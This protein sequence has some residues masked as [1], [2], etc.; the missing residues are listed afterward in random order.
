M[1]KELNDHAWENLHVRRETLTQQVAR[2]I[3]EI[4]MDGGFAPGDRIPT[5]RELCD[6]LNVSRTVVR[7][8]IKALQER[9]L[10][11][12]IPGSGTYISRIEG[13]QISRSISLFVRGN[14]HAFRD[15]LEIRKSLEVEI[16]G[17]AALR[18]SPGEI[19]ELESAVHKM[20]TLLE[21]VPLTADSLEE[22]A[23]ADLEFHQTLAKAS[24]N[25]LL[26]LLLTP[27]TDLVLEFSREASSEH[28][29]PE[30]AVRYHQAI[31][32]CVRQQDGENSRAVMRAHISNAEELLHRMED[33]DKTAPS[34]FL[35]D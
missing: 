26:P 8:G 33:H 27:I 2:R 30:N 29:A 34:A 20:R 25:S 35:K 31:L 9:G 4:I 10:L 1:T 28:G 17:L 13:D 15:L 21:D 12:A 18:A 23:R 19:T 14:T 24:H 5:E 7:E 3:Q 6:R 11:R 16:A 32:E 22:F